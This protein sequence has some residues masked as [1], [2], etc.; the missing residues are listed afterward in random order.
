MEEIPL[1]AGSVDVVISNCV[2]NL[3]VDK[4][5]VLSEI[6]RVLKPGGRL[7]ISDIVAEDQPLARRSRGAGQLLRLHRRRPS[8]GE[9]EAGL[10]A[11]GLER[12][13]ASSSRTVSQTACTPRSSR[14]RSRRVSRFRPGGGYRACVMPHWIALL[15]IVVVAWIVLAVVGGWLIGRGLGIDRAAPTTVDARP[16]HPPA[17]RPDDPAEQREIDRLNAE[18]DRLRDLERHLRRERDRVR[19][20]SDAELER[21]QS[22]LREAAVNAGALDESSTQR[23]ADADRARGSSRRA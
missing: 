1:P 8:K 20:E 12:R 6:A 2:I 5:A 14:R 10:A 19:S 17:S 22:A 23:A 3:S 15:A 18:V 21:L 7:G 16:R 9:Y 11:A 4:Q 13:V